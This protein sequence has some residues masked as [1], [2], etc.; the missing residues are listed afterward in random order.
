LHLCA[1]DLLDKLHHSR[2]CCAVCAAAYARSVR[3]R[4]GTLTRQHRKQIELFRFELFRKRTGAVPVGEVSQPHLP[5]PDICVTGQDCVIGVELTELVTNKRE[6]AQESEQEGVVAA[7]QRHYE[8]KGLPCLGADFYWKDGA[9]VSKTQPRDLAPFLA[10]LVA[11]HVPGIGKEVILDPSWEATEH[12]RHPLFDR[13]WLN[14]VVEYDKNLWGI[15]RSWSVP[16]MVP[17]VV[18]LRIDAKNGRPAQYRVNYSQ[19]WLLITSDGGV[20]SSGF[21][22]T[23]HVLE[24]TY[25]S[26][27]DRVFL[28]VFMMGGIHELKVHRLAA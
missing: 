18:Q 3:P 16:Q 27:F 15:P 28:A 21:D 12:F 4:D 20:P 7:A 6:R 11:S 25:K 5:E 14:R 9:N 2:G 24:H 8:C 22:L 10:Q 19:R 1:N 26:T 13:I 17:G 23:S